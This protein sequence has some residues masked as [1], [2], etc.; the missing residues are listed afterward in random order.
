MSRARW[1][2]LAALLVL[3]D[4]VTKAMVLAAFRPGEGRELTGFFNL[5]LVF[6]KGAAFSFLAGADG[7]QAPL[8]AGFALVAAG[9]VAV[10]GREDP[11][12]G[13]FNAR[14]AVSPCGPLG[15]LGG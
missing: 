10:L 12:Q 9:V 7:W 13:I 14:L 3:A 5:V 8:L 2:I 6:N 15:H 1:F 4:Q 11:A